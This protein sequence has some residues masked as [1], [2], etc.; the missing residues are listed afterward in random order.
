M[1]TVSQVS[2]RSL[3]AFT[4][5]GM[6]SYFVKILGTKILSIFLYIP[7]HR[8]G[9]FRKCKSRCF[10]HQGEKIW[11]VVFTLALSWIFAKTKLTPSHNGR[12]PKMQMPVFSSTFM[13]SASGR[14]RGQGTPELGVYPVLTLFRMGPGK[15]MCKTVPKKSRENLTPKNLFI[16]SKWPHHCLGGFRKRRK[17]GFRVQY[18]PIP[19]LRTRLWPGVWGLGFLGRNP[20]YFITQAAP[21]PCNQ[22]NPSLFLTTTSSKKTYFQ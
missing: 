16:F 17:T 3:A 1:T 5:L 11:V 6:G 9:G 2:S 15:S 7:H 19:L 4:H 10:Q 14:G 21:P 18:Y 12:I 8:A 20:L 13:F 22:P